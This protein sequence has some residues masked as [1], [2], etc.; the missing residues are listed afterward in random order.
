MAG[1]DAGATSTSACQVLGATA[2]R[3][4]AIAVLQLIGDVG[5]VLEA[6]T[7]VADWP[8]GHARL[9]RF[10]D[11]DDGI[12]VRLTDRTAQLM[13]HGG[14]RVVQRLLEW[15]TH[16]GV[17]LAATDASP[18]DLFPEAR[19]QYEALALAA[20]ARAAS[21]LALELLLDQ[22]RRWRQAVELTAEIRARSGRLDRLV[23]PPVVALAGAANV[24]KSTLSNALL[25]RSMSIAADR[26]GTTRDYTSGRIELAGL[27]V[28]WHDT[29]GLR[30]TADPDEMKAVDLARRL[31]DRA[32]LVIA[33]TDAEHGWPDLPKAPQLRVASKADVGRRDD[34]DFSISATT[35]DGIPEL[36]AAIRD[37]LV[38]P[39]DLEHPGP[40][41]F[42]PRLTQQG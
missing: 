14:T 7:G 20:V 1:C 24:G 15:L 9:V 28:D 11:I 42:D 3:P 35:G 27:V 10:G 32:D 6:L 2:L 12:A 25:G 40:W 36:V 18:Q 4:G 29:P 30:E 22:P 16:R 33:M 31:L 34:A 21:P 41:L 26:P 38:P 39:A 19:D 5:P 13:P 8:A 37:R 23:D 17:A